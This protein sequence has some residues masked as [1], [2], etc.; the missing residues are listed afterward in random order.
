[1]LLMGLMTFQQARKRITS[2]IGV[3]NV[4]EGT[5][6]AQT[7]APGGLAGTNTEA[8]G[9]NPKEAINGTTVNVNDGAN[10]DGTKASNA[11]RYDEPAD[12]GTVDTGASDQGE[13]QG[14]N[15]T[16]D[17]GSV[18]SDP[19]ESGTESTGADSDD[20]QQTVKMTQEEFDEINR[21]AT[22]VKAELDK[23]GVEY[24]KDA[25]ADDLRSL[26]VSTLSEAGVLPD[27]VEKV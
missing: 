23:R 15:E 20:D 12:T 1:M 9:S 27:G 17:G 25:K 11:T 3:D 16:G 10:A 18:G 24:A 22:N 14:T 13:T 8:G 26:L 2:H 6:T 4:D 19:G 21:N 5:A 7:P